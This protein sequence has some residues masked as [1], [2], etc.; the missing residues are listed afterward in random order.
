MKHHFPPR[1]TAAATQVAHAL[2]DGQH[3]SQLGGRRLHF[4]NRI[5]IFNL[6]SWYRLICWIEGGFLLRCELMSHER[7]NKLR[8]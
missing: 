2:N 3:W 4:S 7:Y 5:V 8:R 1:V 6:P